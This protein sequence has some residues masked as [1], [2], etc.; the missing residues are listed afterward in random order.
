[1]LGDLFFS[2]Q[3]SCSE[4]SGGP[5][6]LR[7]CTE[8]LSS[9]R[10][11]CQ[12]LHA[13]CVDVYGREVRQLCHYLFLNQF[14]FHMAAYPVSREERTVPPA[15]GC[16]DISLL[17]LQSDACRARLAASQASLAL[18]QTWVS[19]KSLSGVAIGWAGCATWSLVRLVLLSKW[20]STYFWH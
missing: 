19:I 2:L 17:P 11:V 9:T 1:M 7:Y 14:Q 10:A 5:L 18:H 20:H 6:V 13:A 8:T 16:G 4:G 3:Q 15:H 12:K